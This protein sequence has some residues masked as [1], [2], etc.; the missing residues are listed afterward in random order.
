MSFITE[1]FLLQSESAKALYHDYAKM[2]PIL[3]YHNHLPPQD[4]AT[5]RQFKNLYEV[6]L[7]GDHYKWRAMRAN[8]E[9]ESVIVGDAPAKE[10]FLAWARTVPHTLRNPLYH[11]THLELK[12]YFDIDTLLSEETAE[13]IWEET[14]AKLAAPE[15]ATLGLLDQWK[16]KALCTTDDPTESL[17]HH[18]SF[19]AQG[20]DLQMRPTYRPDKALGVTDAEAWNAWV[21]A[22]AAVTNIEINHFD[23][24]VAALRDRHDFFEQ[25]GCRLQDHGLSIVPGTIAAKSVS[26]TIFDKVRAGKDATPEERDT[27][28]AT[29]MLLFS[30]WASEKGWTMQFH[31]GALRNVNQGLFKRF[32]ADIGCDSIDDTPQG[33]RLTR[34]MGAMSA[35]GT[36]PRT[37]LYN[38]NPADNYMLAAMAGNFQDGGIPGKVQFGSGWWFLD[39]KEGMEWQINALSN[40]GLLSRFIGMLTDSRS[41]MSFPRHE[42]FR[43]TLCNL[44]GN[45]IEQ[46]V[47]PNDL[48]MVG[49]MVKNICYQNAAD[50]LRLDEA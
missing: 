35:N 49:G 27:I 38:L 37:V 15:M 42:Y 4:I 24:L 17:E 9:P 21:D 18:A 34:L 19:A 20:H 23:Q 8:G 6:W 3:D 41:F 44:L 14:E 36:L 25:H 33:Q 22:L 39:Q 12:R 47:L 1:D 2:E 46:G 32:G 30:E 40:L 26:E 28:G 31:I 11:W 13:A 29:L 43:R 16:V 7:E 10:K 50:F 45:D 48:L 5:N